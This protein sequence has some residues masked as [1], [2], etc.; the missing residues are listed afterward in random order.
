LDRPVDPAYGDDVLKMVRAALNQT[1]ETIAILR[2]A[3]AAKD[4]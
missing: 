2:E 3:M 4:K 1:P